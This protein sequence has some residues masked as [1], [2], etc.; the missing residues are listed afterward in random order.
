MS[1]CN[2]MRQLCANIWMFPADGIY[3][4]GR[5]QHAIWLSA[6][7]AVESAT[8]TVG[9]RTRAGSEFALAGQLSELAGQYRGEAE[10][11]DDVT[12]RFDFARQES[13]LRGL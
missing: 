10:T 5:S 2:S 6:N 13:A 4:N 7:S 8:A 3:L 9:V 12:L 1:L 11:Q